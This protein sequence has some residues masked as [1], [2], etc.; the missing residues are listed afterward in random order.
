MSWFPLS[1]SVDGDM[2]A[3]KLAQS[4][5]LLS[6]LLSEADGALPG[7]A[8]L[9]EVGEPLRYGAPWV[10]TTRA[11]GRKRITRV[12]TSPTTELSSAIVA[13][14]PDAVPGSRNVLTQGATACGAWV[15]WRV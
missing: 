8:G 5:T 11:L 4:N 6:A 3:D 14:A 13:A 7:T 2:P 10:A 15:E 1:V 9:V 12:T